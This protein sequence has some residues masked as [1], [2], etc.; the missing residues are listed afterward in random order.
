MRIGFGY[1]VH[2]FAEGRPL[3]LGGIEIPADRGLQ[4]HS[5]ADVLLHAV[6]DALLGAAALGDIGVHFPSSDE[7]WRD[8]ESTELLRLVRDRIS[9]EGYRVVNIDATVVLEHPRL[10]PYVERMRATIA[11]CV[12]VGA[13]LISVKATTHEGLGAMGRGEG[14]SAFAVCLL[15][16]TDV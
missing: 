1:D 10:R 12:G 11:D 2:R 9:E 5:D 8:S 13:S 15:E 14:A 3:L 7:R 16:E 6:A 4:G